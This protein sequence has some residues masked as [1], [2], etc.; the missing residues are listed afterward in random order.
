MK[1]FLHL[2]LFASSMAAAID[3][4][5]A[6]PAPAQAPAANVVFFMPG[7]RNGTPNQEV[8]IIL[9]NGAII[10]K[11]ISRYYTGMQH[12]A[13][14]CTD[15]DNA[16]FALSATW[17]TWSSGRS[18]PKPQIFDAGHLLPEKDKCTAIELAQLWACPMN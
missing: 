5:G 12:T 18:C 2:L 1:T 14:G 16:N 10:S 15:P 8:K 3:A 13:P 7:P 4:L 11:K 17:V 6:P 9:A